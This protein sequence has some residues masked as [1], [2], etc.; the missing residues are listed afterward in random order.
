[1]QCMNIHVSEIMNHDDSLLLIG[2]NQEQCFHVFS[3]VGLG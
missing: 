3:L 2:V 1:M